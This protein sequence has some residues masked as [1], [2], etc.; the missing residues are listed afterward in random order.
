MAGIG[1]ELEH[2]QRRLGRAERSADTADVQGEQVQRGDLGDER[3][4]RG[5]R[6]LGAGVRVDDRVGLARDRRALR[7]ADRQRARAA[8]AGVLDGH[9]RVHGLAGL[10]DRDDERVGP[11]TGSR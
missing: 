2:L 10:A 6:D 5:D 1:F 11:I 3:L 8:L 9:E 4:G 7:V